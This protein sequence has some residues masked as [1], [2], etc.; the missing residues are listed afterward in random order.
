[1]SQHKFTNRLAGEKS[2]YLL[3]HAH[4]PVDWY[5]W[6][7]EAIRKAAAEDKPVF[8][9]VGYATCHWCHV[10]ERESFEDEEVAE[11]LRRDFVC[12]KVDREE[13]PDIDQ[14][15]MSA[16]QAITGRGGWPMSVFLAPDLKPFWG[17][18]YFPRQAFLSILSQIS[19]SWKHEREKIADSG[20]QIHQMLTQM[21][22]TRRQAGELDGKV[23]AAATAQ[24]A[25]QF[26]PKWGGFGGAPKFPR[27]AQLRLL[28]RIA[29]RSGDERVLQMVTHTLLRMAAGG[30]Y[31]HVGGGFAR[32]SV[33][34]RWEIPHF[35]KMLY[36]NAGLAVIYTE[37]FQYTK[38]PIFAQVVR[39]ILDYVLRDMTHPEGGFYSA[40]DADSEGHEGKFYVWSDEEFRSLLTADEY[41]ELVRHFEISPH[42]NFEGKTNLMLRRPEDFLARRTGRLDSALKKLFAAR[43]KRIR[44]LLDDKILT[45]WNGLMIAAMAKAGQA[46]SEPR[47]LD[48]AR[49]ALAFVRRHL[50]QPGRLMRRWRDGE[51]A[52]AGTLDDYAYLVDGVLQLAE[53]DPDLYPLVLELQ[54]LQDERF[55]DTAHAGYF[56]T[57]GSDPT[58]LVRTRQAEDEAVPSPNGVSALN[59]LRIYH[60]TFD[61]NRLRQAERMFE[62]FGGLAARYPA[63]FAALIQAYDFHHDETKEV[64]IAGTPDDPRTGFLIET[65]YSAYVP[66]RV[67]VLNTGGAA[68]VKLAQG[69]DP[70]AGA[71][72]A[73]VCADNSCLRPTADPAEFAGQLGEIRPIKLVTVPPPEE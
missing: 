68:P 48:A 66:N 13:R 57:D 50:Y 20:K 3:Q 31:D 15:Y 17:G 1:M 24:S 46:L 9:S 26:D 56:Y 11:A 19:R 12:I 44:P 37:A 73:Y 8:L 28:L 53:S 14:I 71:P 47:Y 55:W 34:E 59:L 70:I 42:G 40:E 72:V 61:V 29:R 39:E 30:I 51:A 43:V 7:E 45:S 69:K 33:D 58:V 41:A 21:A 4:N 36:D 18:T 60:L 54:A 38:N 64:V 62:G 16:V 52:V 22:E 6:G 25:Q 35:E 32:Y 10:M 65:L 63:Y 23:F 2:P 67:V 5:P 27:P 49:K